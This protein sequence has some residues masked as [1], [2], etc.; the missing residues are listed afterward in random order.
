MQPKPGYFLYPTQRHEFHRFIHF[1]SD[2]HYRLA[3]N[4]CHSRADRWCSC[5]ADDLIAVLTFGYLLSP[6]N[7]A[8]AP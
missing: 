6:S 4:S 1:N 5:A 3:Q 2:S 8:V 7:Q